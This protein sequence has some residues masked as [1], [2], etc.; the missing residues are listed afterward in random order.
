MFAFF[1]HLF[2]IFSFIFLFLVSLCFNFFFMFF[3]KMSM[4]MKQCSFFL[5]FII[6]K[7]TLGLENDVKQNVHEGSKY[8]QP[9]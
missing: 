6:T 1:F 2:F 9:D 4:C 3:E 5:I 8:A 7:C